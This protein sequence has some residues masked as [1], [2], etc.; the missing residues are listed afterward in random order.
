M[1]AEHVLDWSTFRTEGFGAIG[2][3][4]LAKRPIHISYILVPEGSKTLHGSAS[5]RKDC[6]GGGRGPTG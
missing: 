1:Y 5:T 4:L 6:T 2:L 3:G